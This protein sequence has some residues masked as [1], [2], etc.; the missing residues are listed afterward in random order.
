ML[1]RNAPPKPVLALRIG[2]TGH[3][4]NKLSDDAALF[5]GRQAEALLQ[6][7]QS[8]LSHIA[9]EYSQ[10]YADTKP[11]ARIVTALAEGADRVVADAGLRGNTE[12]DVIIPFSR[13]DY[14][15]DFDVP[16]ARDEF[17]ALLGRASTVIELDGRYEPSEGRS[18]AYAAAG[19]KV[20]R[21][22][23][24]LIA[25]WDGG[26]ADG[27]GGTAEIIDYALHNSCPVIWL[28]SNG[29]PFECYGEP[30]RLLL[31]ERSV[32]KGAE[33]ELLKWLASWLAPPDAASDRDGAA[34]AA[35]PL[36]E[37][38][39][40]RRPSLPLYRLY[41]RFV[42]LVTLGGHRAAAPAAKPAR[43]IQLADVTSAAGF[44]DPQ[45][46]SLQRHY[47]WL[48]TLSSY[49]AGLYRSAF[50]VNYMLAAVAVLGAATGSFAGSIVEFV[51][52]VLILALTWIGLRRRW[53][54]R[55]IDYR[56]TAE[57]LRTT[58][59]LRLVASPPMTPQLPPHLSEA[60]DS[61]FGWLYR[62]IMREC[63][64][65]SIVF[66]SE[67]LTLVRG[68]LMDEELS[69]QIAY[70]HRNSARLHV[71]DHR[72]HILSLCSFALAFV[73]ALSH[74]FLEEPALEY[75]SI[76]LPT[77]GAA[78]FGV[79]NHGEFARV[80]DRSKR[81]EVALTQIRDELANSA[82]ATADRQTLE[83]KAQI[84][85][86]TMLSETNEWQNLVRARPLEL[87]A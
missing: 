16:A 31:P 2:V 34:D 36:H 77:I 75:L 53:H 71:F 56:D 10:A 48:D 85:A 21:Q 52:L 61:N 87:P 11:C 81:M 59:F 78:L 82:S 8:R 26:G 32:I 24:I 65:P 6:R 73:V 51:S 12:I 44:H 30:V 25:V 84:I 62:A 9:T 49:Y 42:R 15:K 17:Y 14:A 46:E 45:S 60:P 18:A 3:R 33:D 55:W 35:V 20:V 54:Q 64:L 79:R 37:Y 28:P 80:S 47:D 70:H 58:R 63:G 40:E 38:F 22:A 66:T 67:Y 86:Q 68:Y 4:P 23:D 27:R 19:M 74:F 72:L 50:L 57:K 7:I 13:S 29:R 76:A 69:G 83:L 5:V 1:A 39:R 41:D 43:K